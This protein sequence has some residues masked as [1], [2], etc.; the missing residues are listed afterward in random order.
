MEAGYNLS[1]LPS[2]PEEG[3]RQDGGAV[4]VLLVGRARWTPVKRAAVSDEQESPADGPMAQSAGQAA[5]CS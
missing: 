3:Q 4:D 5:Q 2:L 1:P